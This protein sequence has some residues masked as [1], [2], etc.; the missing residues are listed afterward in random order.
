M[1]D[2]L[3]FG[4]VS[5]W[6]VYVSY[7]LYGEEMNCLDNLEKCKASCCKQVLFNVPGNQCE[8]LIVI[9]TM[10]DDKK[11]Y[12]NL[13]GLIVNR[14]RNR[15]WEINI[16]TH[17]FENAVMVTISETMGLL[18]VPT[19]C[20]ALTIENKCSF[21]GTD[22]KPSICKALNEETANSEKIMVTD[23]CIYGS[24]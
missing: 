9:S 24:N 19:I 10:T 6:N 16:P 13:H 22:K 18:K 4:I 14:L 8:N 3:E 11:H 7:L 17:I 15:L 23:G 2:I 21:H 5:A 1:D 20:K 12:Y